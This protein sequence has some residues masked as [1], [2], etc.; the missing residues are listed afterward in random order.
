MQHLLQ[1]RCSPFLKPEQAMPQYVASDH[2]EN[3]HSLFVKVRP[4]DTDHNGHLNSSV[5]MPFCVD[6]A[7]EA[8]HSGKL[9]HFHANMASYHVRRMR[10]LYLR[11]CLLGK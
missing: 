3:A 9:H 10:A 6:C 8:A 2:P 4:S 7:S 11:E 5:Y 1:A